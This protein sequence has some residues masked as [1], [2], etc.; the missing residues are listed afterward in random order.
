MTTS[1]CRQNY[2]EAVEAA[3]NKQINLELYA[4]HV[5]LTIANYFDQDDVALKG[6]HHYFSK[7]SDEEREHARKMMHYQNKRGGRVML[8]G[9]EDPPAPGNWNSPLSSMQF[10]LFME[11]KV[12]QSLLELHAL[13]SQHNDAQFCDFL[14]SEFLNE[15]VESIKELG[16]H[17]TNIKRVGEGLGVYMFDRELQS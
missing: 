1:I 9:V 8:A 15:Q 13:S 10:A 5:Y 3:L 7:Q 6:F 4:S 12:N 14:E 16:D 17:I 2:Q 11:K